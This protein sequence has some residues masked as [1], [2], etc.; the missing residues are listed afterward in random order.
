MRDSWEVA[1]GQPYANND[2]ISE[3]IRPRVARAC[4]AARY[5][6]GSCSS[7][8]SGQSRRAETVGCT[9]PR[10]TEIVVFDSLCSSAYISALSSVDAPAHPSTSDERVHHYRYSED[11]LPT[12]TSPLPTY[13]PI[14]RSPQPSSVSVLRRVS[15]RQSSLHH[16]RLLSTTKIQA[17]SRRAS[18]PTRAMTRCHVPARSV[19]SYAMSWVVKGPLYWQL[20][21]GLFEIASPS[22]SPRRGR[23]ELSHAYLARRIPTANHSDVGPSGATTRLSPRMSLV[24]YSEGLGFAPPAQRLLS[25]ALHARALHVRPGASSG[26]SPPSMS[27]S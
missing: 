7:T 13:Y 14:R 27:R 15:R 16:P 9:H 26:S 18:L 23:Q 12:T 1:R 3:L 25:S 2:R 22:P 19:V 11:A 21:Y 20:V 8:A 10:A 5:A 4:A 24:T 6:S 17:S